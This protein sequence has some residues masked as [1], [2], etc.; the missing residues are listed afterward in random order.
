MNYKNVKFYFSANKDLTNTRVFVYGK[1]QVK[2][3]DQT[4][5]EDAE[6]CNVYLSH[7][8]Q[9]HIHIISV[10]LSCAEAWLIQKGVF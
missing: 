7:E 6:G 5:D 3:T 10:S 2:V 4:E 1:S 9:G 8:G